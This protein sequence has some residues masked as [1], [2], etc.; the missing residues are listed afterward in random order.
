M[1]PEEMMTPPVVYSGVVYIATG[2]VTTTTV[3]NVYRMSTT[4]PRASA[5]G[6]PSSEECVSITEK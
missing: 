3:V 4:M 2:T 6:F 5:L 1:Q